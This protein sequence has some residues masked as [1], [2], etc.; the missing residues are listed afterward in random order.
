MRTTENHGSAP[1]IVTLGPLMAGIA[2]SELDQVET[3][4]LRHP[5]VGGVILFSRNYRDREQLRTL[6]DSIHALRQPPLLIAVDHE[7]GRV[8]R[9]RDGFTALPAAAQY[10]ILHDRNPELAC[11]AARAGGWVMAVELRAGGVD[12]S[13]AP[14][15]DLGRGMS[16]VIGDR[17]FHHDPDVVTAL[18]RAFLAGMRDAEVGGIGKHFPGHGGV[19]DDSH[20]ALPVDDRS[21]ED[22]RLSD[23]VPFERLAASDLAGVMPAHVVFECLDVRPAGFSHRWIIDILRGE[24]GF[25]GIVFS[26]DLDMAAAATGGDHV[27]R[28]HA[29]LEAG[30]DLVLVCNDWPSAIAVVDGLKIGSD[31]VRI[32]RMARM[33]GRGAPSFQ[34]LASD[35]AYRSA[36]AYISSLARKPELELGDDHLV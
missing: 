13:F 1:R 7:G 9:F 21:Y 8:Q 26:D 25:Q 5:S 6:C 19:A 36:V 32:A 3:E 10:G 27:D 16:T 30:C 4:V 22:L 18:A 20:C 34:Q 15:L 2:G 29:A 23:L 14:V 33:H 35:A 28:A 24:L 11:R 31:P 12:C 17:A